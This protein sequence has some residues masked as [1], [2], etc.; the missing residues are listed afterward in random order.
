MNTFEAKLM[1]FLG[2]ITLAGCVIL[3]FVAMVDK[4]VGHITDYKTAQVYATSAV[5][6][7]RLNAQSTITVA[8]MQ[9]SWFTSM[10][11]CIDYGGV[12]G[13]GGFSWL[14]IGLFVVVAGV[15]AW[16]WNRESYD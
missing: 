2:F 5:D 13:V 1:G 10:K 9:N 11:S 3:G 6:I 4:T 7:A 14:T 8:C 16:W 12:N 15:F